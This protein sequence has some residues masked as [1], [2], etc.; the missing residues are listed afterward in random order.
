MW[1]VFIYVRG[2]IRM[3]SSL[4]Q[5]SLSVPCKVFRQAMD[6]E[7]T[8]DIIVTAATLRGYSCLLV[9]VSC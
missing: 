8:V 4:V 1:F 3:L 6:G 9:Y 2:S 7:P 5:L